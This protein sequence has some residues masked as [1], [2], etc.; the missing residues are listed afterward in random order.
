MTKYSLQLKIKIVNEANNGASYNSLARKY[1]ISRS[2]IVEWHLLVQRHGFQALDRKGKRKY[3][4]DFKFKVVQDY[5][6]S[7]N[8]VVDTATKYNVS[9]SQVSSWYHIVKS[10]GIGG[11]RPHP[12]GR[13]RKM[14]KK[15]KS[16]NNNS[17]M[18]L[19]QKERYEQ[20]IL[21]LKEKLNYAEMERDILKEFL[22]L[23][24]SK[25]LKKRK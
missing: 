15:K 23:D 22:A 4:S 16:S 5:I 18:T 13:P 24:E 8:G 14:T 12:K 2:N 6:S 10:Q 17:E 7:P 9:T 25:P 1:N 3:S 11:L 21:E 19:S 20:E